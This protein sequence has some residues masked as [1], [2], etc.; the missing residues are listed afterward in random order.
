MSQA[1]GSLLEQPVQPGECVWPRGENVS[2]EPACREQTERKLRRAV[3]GTQIRRRQRGRDL[4]HRPEVCPV[5]LVSEE[6]VPISIL[7]LP[8]PA[9]YTFHSLSYRQLLRAITTPLAHSGYSD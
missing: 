6:V 4:L 7:S 1:L 8:L 5:A 9:R 3:A 2:W